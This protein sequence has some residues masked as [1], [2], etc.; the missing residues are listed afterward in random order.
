MV[1]VDENDTDDDNDDISDG[2]DQYTNGIG[3]VVTG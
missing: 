3:V 1:P 2:L